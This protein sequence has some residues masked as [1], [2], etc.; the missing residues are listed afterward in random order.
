MSKPEKISIDGVDY[1]R[2]DKT[3]PAEKLDGLEYVIVR[4]DRA[5]VFAGYLVS[6]TATPA[7]VEVV[8]RQ[9]RRLW[10]WSGAASCSELA[11]SGPAN[12]QECKF[13]APV[14]LALISGVIEQLPASETA[15]L[16]IASVPV[17]SASK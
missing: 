3:A 10:Y 7:G 6:R 13:P 2:S 9:C 12:K 8:I 14:S 5:G 11:I 15:R 16:A 4:A 1:V 17:W